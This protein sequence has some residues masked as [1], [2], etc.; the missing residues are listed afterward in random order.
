MAIPVTAVVS[1]ADPVVTFNLNGSKYSSTGGSVATLQ[2][3]E[4]CGLT[5]APQRPGPGGLATEPAA[6][7]VNSPFGWLRFGGWYTNQ[8]CTAPFAFDAPVVESLTLYAKWIV[9]EEYYIQK[10]NGLSMEQSMNVK[11][12]DA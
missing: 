12:W 8:A 7:T 2:G 10:Y 9:D 6:P 4:Y 5:P 1:E 11:G 3:L